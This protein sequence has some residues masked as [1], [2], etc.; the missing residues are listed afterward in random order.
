MCICRNSLVFGQW[1]TGAKDRDTGGYSC[2][3]VGTM[4]A[5]GI[6][7]IVYFSLHIGAL[8]SH[9]GS[10]CGLP[11]LVLI[12]NVLKLQPMNLLDAW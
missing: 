11:S 7:C 9:K 12:C 2:C 10:F 3:T 6:R 1:L 4:Q 8:C 5:R